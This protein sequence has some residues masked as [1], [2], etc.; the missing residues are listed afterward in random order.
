MVYEGKMCLN[1]SNLFFFRPPLTHY[2]T[3]GLLKMTNS[4]MLVVW[5][6]T[7]YSLVL[8]PTLNF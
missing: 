2:E 6:P 3:L 4:F 5:E 1:T 7:Y 8:D